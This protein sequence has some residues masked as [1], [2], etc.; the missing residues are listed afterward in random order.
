MDVTA[1]NMTNV[2]PISLYFGPITKMYLKFMS[3]F[4]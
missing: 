2:G 4:L 3:I 1:I